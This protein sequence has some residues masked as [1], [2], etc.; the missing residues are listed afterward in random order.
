MLCIVLAVANV[1]LLVPELTEK[2]LRSK[3][4]GMPQPSQK[5]LPYQVGNG[6]RMSRAT[7]RLCRC[8]W[9]VVSAALGQD[10]AATK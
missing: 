5:Q 8:D 10:I 2:S 1:L 9:A 3:Q 7:W 4:V 6:C